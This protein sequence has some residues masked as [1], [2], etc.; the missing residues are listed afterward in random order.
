MSLDAFLKISGVE[1]ESQSDAHKG[2]IAIQGFS[3][4]VNMPT[5]MEAGKGLVKG[6]ASISSIS[7]SHNYDKASPVLQKYCASGKHFDEMVLTCAQNSGK[8]LDFYTITLSQCMI[9]SCQIGAASGGEIQEN[10]T[11]AFNEIKTEYKPT[12]DKDGTLGGSVKFGWN[13]PTEVIT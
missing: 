13:I 12:V 6:K 3:W 11:I 9:E 4:G 7:F 2:E 10:V 1:A 5:H 8:K